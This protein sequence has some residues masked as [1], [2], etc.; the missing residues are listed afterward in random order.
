MTTAELLPIFREQFPEYNSKSDDEILLYLNNA[1]I[2]HALCEMAT[3]Y[4]AAHLITIDS[5]SGV[6]G[7]GGSVD[8]GGVRET[9]SETAKSVSASFKGMAKDGSNDS[10]YTNTPY[11]RMYITLRNNCPGKRF[12]VRVA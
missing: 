9:S 3:V 11:G 2:I 1:L 7:S 5:E 8:G 6:G 12:S 10:F 4:L